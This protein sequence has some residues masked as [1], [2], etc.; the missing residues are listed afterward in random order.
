[1][2]KGEVVGGVQDSLPIEGINV[3]LGNNFAG[4]HVW[5]VESPSPKVSA[6][7]SFVGFP[8][9][10][11]QSFVVRGDAVHEPWRPGH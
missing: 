11:A 4:E 10:S 5:P 9:E 7:P 8:D 6:K 1:M 3:I 2:V